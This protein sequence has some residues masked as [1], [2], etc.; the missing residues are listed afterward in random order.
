MEI[1]YEQIAGL[2]LITVVVSSNKKED[3]VEQL[4]TKRI[5]IRNTITQTGAVRTTIHVV[6][7]DQEVSCTHDMHRALR[8]YNQG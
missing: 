8:V 2:E 5:E 1:A 6:V 4:S 3:G 7:N